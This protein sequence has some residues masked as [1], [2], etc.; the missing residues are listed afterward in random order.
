[1][2]LNKR[3]L[4][5]LLKSF[6]FAFRG[7]IYC[8]K[9]ERNM[10]IHITAALIVLPFS[11]IYDLTRPEYAILILIMG[12]VMVCELINTAIETL[13]NLGSESYD[14]LARIA[15]DVA[16]GAVLMCAIA[17]LMVAVALFGHKD[18]LLN[19]LIK[20]STTPYYL[21]F[22]I[23]LILIGILFIFKGFKPNKG[24]NRKKKDEVKIYTPKP[25][26]YKYSNNTEEVKIYT[27]NQNKK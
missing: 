2:S 26:V 13:V 9:N 24:L 16:A 4:K 3:E 18:K 27:L 6:T 8:I 5:G 11:F 10:R 23:I 25:S 19:T 22:F 14:S 1:M 17:A 7:L 12:M 15:K 20:I 21:I